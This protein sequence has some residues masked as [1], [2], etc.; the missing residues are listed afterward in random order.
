MSRLSSRASLLHN[1]DAQDDDEHDLE[2]ERMMQPIHRTTSEGGSPS[3]SVRWMDL[4]DEP[5]AVVM[6]AEHITRLLSQS[7]MKS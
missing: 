3:R 7:D 1:P 2:F 6:T 5:E 4:D